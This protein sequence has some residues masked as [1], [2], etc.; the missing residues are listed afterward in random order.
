MVYF[1]LMHFL[2]IQDWG[3]PKNITDDKDT[4]SDF[5]GEGYG[6]GGYGYGYGYGESDDPA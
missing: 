6:G 1:V 4:M 3:E 5:G 2:R